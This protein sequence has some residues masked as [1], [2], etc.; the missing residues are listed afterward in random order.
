MNKLH[1][2]M[3]RFHT[4]SMDSKEFLLMLDP[5]IGGRVA[6]HLAIH[7]LPIE[8]YWKPVKFVLKENQDATEIPDWSFYT[9]GNLILNEKAKAAL[10]PFLL[11]AGELL[12]LES[13]QGQYYFFNCLLKV[14]EGEE[15]PVGRD[16]YK[17]T[18]AVGIDLICSQVFRDAVEKAQLAGIYFTSDVSA[19]A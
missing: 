12:P 16:L 7:N 6:M 15:L 13:D 10:E 17:A 2:N 11:E 8:E 5:H 9:S 4:L 18:P 14:D 3:N 19:L 1:E